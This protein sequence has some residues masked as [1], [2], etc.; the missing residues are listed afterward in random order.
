MQYIFLCNISRKM[1][2][3]NMVFCM[4]INIK[5]LYML[6]ALFLL[7]IARH[8]Q[9]TQNK[10]F[11]ISQKRREG[12]SSFFACRYSSNYRTSWYNKSWW[13]WP[14]LL[15]L[16]KITSLQNRKN[17]VMKLMLCMLI[18]MKVFYKLIVLFLMG[19]ARDSQI[20]PLNL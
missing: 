3:I 9:I 11:A 17:W 8:V 19:L 12:W 14:G 16:P 15:K 18:N 2:E 6:V 7:V 1:W 13:A 20:T 5:D 4:K 10:K